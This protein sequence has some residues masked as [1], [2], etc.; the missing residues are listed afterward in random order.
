MNRKQRLADLKFTEQVR[1]LL[2][3]LDLDNRV[4][5]SLIY[6]IAAWQTPV[7]KIPSFID[8]VT[9][10][11]LFEFL[12]PILKKHN[13][14]GV[15]I[16]A[17]DA[18]KKTFPEDPSKKYSYKILESQSGLLQ[19]AIIAV[20]Q[21]LDALNSSNLEKA[22]CACR[23]SNESS[24]QT[25]HQMLHYCFLNDVI[26]FA[27]E[28]AASPEEQNSEKEFQLLFFHQIL[29]TLSSLETLNAYKLFRII[30]SF[31]IHQTI[32]P[33]FQEVI[34]TKSLIWFYKYFP[35]AMGNIHYQSPASN[36]DN[37]FTMLITII[38]TKNKSNLS[39]QDI[40]DRLDVIVAE[41][42]VNTRAKLVDRFS[43]VSAHLVPSSRRGAYDVGEQLFSN[44]VAPISSNNLQHQEHERLSE[45]NDDDNEALWN[46]WS[47]WVNGD[48]HSVSEIDSNIKKAAPEAHEDFEQS[49]K[50]RRRNVD[51]NLTAYETNELNQI[52]LK[53]S[54]ESN[55]IDSI[56]K[57]S[58]VLFNNNIDSETLIALK[59]KGCSLI[60]T[61]LIAPIHSKYQEGK[62]YDL[63]F[64][65]ENTTI[66]SSTTSYTKIRHTQVKK[67]SIGRESQSQTLIEASNFIG[68]KGIDKNDRFIFIMA[69]R[70][71]EAFTPDPSTNQY[72]TV[73][74]L[75]EN[76]YGQLKEDKS[77]LYP[78]EVL[79]VKRRINTTTASTPS[80]ITAR[81]RATIEFALANELNHF[82][83]L[84]DNINMVEIAQQH[85][86]NNHENPYVA[87]YNLMLEKTIHVNEPLTSLQT[88]SCH[89]QWFVP[90]MLGCKYFLFNL[91]VLRSMLRA[92]DETIKPNE[93]GFSIF[94]EDDATGQQDYYMQ[95]YFHSLAAL[96]N[97]QNTHR[98]GFD[99]FPKTT[100][101]I[102]RSG[103]NRN[104]AVAQNNEL[105]EIYT[106]IHL[107]EQVIDV[108][109]LKLSEVVDR[110]TLMYNSIILEAEKQHAEKQKNF[111]N[112]DYIVSLSSEEQDYRLVNER[113]LASLSLED[114]LNTVA[115]IDNLHPHQ[116]DALSFYKN[117]LSS[118][119]SDIN[120][121]ICTGGGKTYIQGLIAFAHFKQ[122]PGK[123]VVIV[124]PTQHI[125]IQFRDALR[126]LTVKEWLPQELQVDPTKINSVLSDQTTRSIIQAHFH[127]NESLQNKS[128]ILVICH[129]SFKRLIA[130]QSPEYYN[131][132]FDLMKKTSVFMFDEAHLT[133]SYDPN[134]IRSGEAL[135]TSIRRLNFTATPIYQ[136][137]L[138]YEFNIRQGV[139]TKILAHFII[140]DTF[141]ARD[142]QDWDKIA[143]LVTHHPMPKSNKALKDHKGIIY[144]SSISDARDLFNKLVAEGFT[145]YEIHSNREN[146]NADIHSFKEAETGIAIAVDMLVEGFDCSDVYWSMILKDSLSSY[147]DQRKTILDCD[148]RAQILGRLLR[149]SEKNSSKQ[150]L[151]ILPDN[152]R[153]S[154]LERDFHYKKQKSIQSPIIL[155]A[156][157]MYPIIPAPSSNKNSFFAQKK[158]HNP[159]VQQEDKGNRGS[160]LRKRSLEEVYP[161]FHS[162]KN[163]KI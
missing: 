28:S 150:A 73:L 111:F 8:S 120:F 86:Q 68:F 57:N 69:G 146:S 62:A 117:N 4:F 41:N 127:W 134:K 7:E 108:G 90:N 78:Y 25:T 88:K 61:G 122:Q 110:T 154:S 136:T 130:P 153:L 158:S 149:A 2:E 16:D 29:T 6:D 79:L 93:I 1:Q 94:P 96:T 124:C 160:L 135:P 72:R 140:D 107:L 60:C 52:V 67:V 50:R 63:P 71:Q 128:N 64:S 81:R 49:P 101:K 22:L 143:S 89:K 35:L 37:F 82:L 18:L 47:A 17:L 109:G 144:V 161:A 102:H 11:G 38:V 59:N 31:S 34:K 114:Y 142:I 115:T 147:N 51:Q 151:L 125:C 58:T 98:R 66:F 91:N 84:D 27:R 163:V 9:Q 80:M 65:H 30:C 5:D 159:R 32:I 76:E 106:T 126:E 152:F 148:K 85:Y 99:L 103:L 137:P 74:V 119:S 43:E 132:Q 133:S 162:I 95:L 121:T 45:E 83:M 23:P 92:L 156:D 87:I 113:S 44:Y 70:T 39:Y 54:L 155:V 75:T 55:E 26:I 3:P 15:W 12:I 138:Q 56:P 77:S 116:R 46:L 100:A 42:N 21:K 123:N 131:E 118:T 24:I 129:E 10:K 40:I 36:R 145:C 20:L 104:L 97:D 105:S 112:A 19:Y 33:F 53:Q 14:H 48:E 139:A 157:T 141:S 13:A